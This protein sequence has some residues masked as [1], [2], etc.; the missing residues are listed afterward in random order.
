MSHTTRVN[1]VKIQDVRA[2]RSAVQDLK[3]SGVNCELEE[4][5]RPRMYFKQQEV[6]CDYVLRLKDGK[7]DLGFE[8]QADGSYTPIFDEH[9]NYVGGQIGAACPMPNTKEGRT[10]HQIGRFMQNYAK[11]AAMN[12]ARDKGQLVES[13]TVDNQ[14]RVKIT[15]GGF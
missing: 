11:H 6:Q 2:L 14:G 4:N 12:A 5:A 3:N 13:C 1:T 9:A 8:K 15:I 10:Q 7:Y